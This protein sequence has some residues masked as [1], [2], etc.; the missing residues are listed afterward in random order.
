MNDVIVF[1]GP[2]LPLARARAVLEAT[3]L[4]P[5]RQGDVFRALARRPRVIV[6][7]DGVFEA[8]PSVWHHE[9]R[10]ALASGVRV[11]G[12]SS[13]GALRAAELQRFG[14]KPI[15][16]I[17]TEYARG[18]RIDD[19]DVVLLHG[20]ADSGYRPL[21]V[22]LVTVQATLREAQAKGVVS[23]REASALERRAAALF[24]R[25][26]TWRGLID[27]M[28]RWSSAKKQALRSWVR[29]H[30][31]DPKAQ[32]ALE[33][34]AVAGRLRDAPDRA[35]PRALRLSSFVRR[36]RLVDVA[37][38]RVAA[39]EAR[40]DAGRLAEDGV[41]RLLLAEFAA[42]AGIRPTRDEVAAALAQL[43]G[44]GL[45]P[46]EHLRLASAVALDR[47]VVRAPERFVA[48]GPSRLEGLDLAR[49]LQSR[50]R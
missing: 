5:A 34:L 29:E 45:S 13:M 33:A 3:Y 18:Q 4:P 17:A 9:L 23:A 7:I 28:P 44:R 41:R 22:P 36:R 48:D 30:L 35:S 16:R 25:E 31:V 19:A 42:L 10:A 1:L 46:D 12:A 27:G 40:A 6:L 20:D 47:L 43:D 14:M 39:L 11:L 50:A 38:A 2:S 8:V 37:P 32:D 26:R 21:T 49:R 24:Y 15:G